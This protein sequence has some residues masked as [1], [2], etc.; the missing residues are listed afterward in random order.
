[1]GHYE[2]ETNIPMSRMGPLRNPS[3]SEP[4]P[5]AYTPL[6]PEESPEPASPR[7]G[8]L[9]KTAI[10]PPPRPRSESVG[11]SSHIP[12][13]PIIL[14]NTMR[15]VNST[16][17]LV[18]RDEQF[19]QIIFEHVIQPRLRKGTLRGK[20]RESFHYISQTKEDVRP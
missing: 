1:M 19:A 14:S 9:T 20:D 6:T 4:P 11:S 13:T 16:D 5:Y 17:P 10:S 12:P 2:Q 7:P 3:V 18:I 15:P 8:R